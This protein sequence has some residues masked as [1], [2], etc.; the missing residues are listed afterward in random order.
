[1]NGPLLPL[2]IVD[3]VLL[4]YN[5]GD[6]LLLLFALSVLAAIV[7]RSRKA[8]SAQAI[9]FGLILV[10]TPG[11]AL[12]PGDGSLFGSILQYKF[13]GLVLV[14]AGPVLYMTAKR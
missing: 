5:V 9:A 13:F 6:V 3:S 12:E 1:M 7:L 10:I 14:L 11:G 2:Q 4:K 8:F